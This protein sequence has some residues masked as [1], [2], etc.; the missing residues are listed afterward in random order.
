MTIIKNLFINQYRKNQNRP[1]TNINTN[2]QREK[3]TK[4]LGQNNTESSFT[5]QEIQEE[6][7]KLKEK[8]KSPRELYVQEY[9]YE[10]IAELLNIPLGTIKSR[11][12]FAKKELAK[13]LINKDSSYKNF[14]TKKL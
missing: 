13:A 2:E 10:E 3:I 8:L 6:T 14:V 9:K 1:T 7:N 11:I 4:D 12:F 5:V